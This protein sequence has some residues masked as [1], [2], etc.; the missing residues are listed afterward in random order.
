M[1]I[2]V[3]ILVSI[4]VFGL[5]IFIHELGH[6]LCAKAFHVT[7]D[8]FALGMGPT[9]LKRQVKGTVYALR[10][11]P[12]GGFVK[13]QGEEK[14]EEGECSDD[15][16]M[17]YNKPCWQRII[18]LAAGAFMNLLLG[19]VLSL[20]MTL[21]QSHIATN[22]VARFEENALSAQSGLALEDEILKING[23]SVLTDRDIVTQLLSD[24]DGSYQ[25]IVRR[26][27]EKMTLNGVKLASQKTESGE[28]TL[29]L[30]FKVYSYPKT[31]LSTVKYTWNNFL[32]LARSI[33]LSLGDLISG[34]VGFSQLSGPVGVGK[35]I[36]QA[37]SAGLETFFYIFA[38]ITINIGIFN[39]LPIPA[40]DGGRLIFVLIELIIRKPVPGK[41][42]NMIHFVGLML[43]LLLMLAVTAKDILGLFR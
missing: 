15:P 41:Y 26:N 39:L 12:I 3:T 5:I 27:G 11:F 31:F 32:S 35:V 17:F 1:N 29:I 13:M 40:L 18:I 38:F 22:I 10:L 14:T 28:N 43:L 8:E 37:A 2:F 19:L 36:G 42:E 20:V 6:F 7:V 33:W 34:K 4:L 16:G 24:E 21:S 9:L 25:F 23:V 30:D